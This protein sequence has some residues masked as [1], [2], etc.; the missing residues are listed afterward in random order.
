MLTQDLES[1]SARSAPG[2][3]WSPRTATYSC[4]QLRCRRRALQGEPQH[5]HAAEQI[6]AEQHACRPPGRERRERERDPSFAGG[7]SLRPTGAR[8]RS[9]RTRQP[10]HRARRR[11][12]RRRSAPAAPAAPARAPTTATRPPRARP[13]PGASERGTRPS[14]PRA[15]PRNRPADD[16]RATRGR[17]TAH[18]PALGSGARQG[19][20][21]STRPSP[22]NAVKPAPNNVS[23]RPVAY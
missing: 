14:P 15:P 5:G 21:L 18:R 23:A 19:S 11:T 12:R 1:G 13:D 8:R 10:G 7:Q 2:R 20:C 6:G 3:G 4:K 22:A 16:S 17:A 9:I